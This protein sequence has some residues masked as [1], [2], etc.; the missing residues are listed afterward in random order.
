MKHEIMIS[1]GGQVAQQRYHPDPSSF[2]SWN[3]FYNS[4]QLLNGDLELLE[5]YEEEVSVILDNNWDK[6]ESVANALL[7]TG[8]LTGEQVRTF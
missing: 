3:D 5:E 1:L 4:Y 6:V 8:S 2:R 7:V